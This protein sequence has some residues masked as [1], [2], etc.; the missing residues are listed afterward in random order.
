MPMDKDGDYDRSTKKK[1]PEDAPIGT[2]I[3]RKGVNTIQS[4]MAYKDYQMTKMGAGETPV[5]FEEWKAGKR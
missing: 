4:A 1:K 3:A 2:G 5:S